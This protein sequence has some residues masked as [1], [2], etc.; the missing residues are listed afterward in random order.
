MTDPRLDLLVARLEHGEIDRRTFVVRSVAWG[1]SAL[2]AASAPGNVTAQEAGPA[3][4][5]ELIPESLGVPDVPHSTETGKGAINLDS[6]WPLI[7]AA[8]QVGG[9][10]AAAIAFAVEL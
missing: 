10:S 8:E 6:S 4:N 9:D 2:T 3:A 1:V 5:I 7:A